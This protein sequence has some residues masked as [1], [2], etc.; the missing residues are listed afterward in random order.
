MRAN[1]LHLEFSMAAMSFFAEFIKTRTVYSS[2]SRSG[3]LA[4]VYMSP[5]LAANPEP[6][7]CLPCHKEN[8][9][10]KRKSSLASRRSGIRKKEGEI[11]AGKGV[12]LKGKKR[13]DAAQSTV[14]RRVATGGLRERKLTV[15]IRAAIGS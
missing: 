6:R 9:Q 10:A 13:E 7:P 4:S 5:F 14:T 11:Y 2:Q 1:T 3:A 12:E 8:A 15:L